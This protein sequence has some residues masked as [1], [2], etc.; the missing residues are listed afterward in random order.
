[1]RKKSFGT[2]IHIIYQ[3]TRGIYTPITIRQ[4]QSQ[5]SHAAVYRGHQNKKKEV[6]ILGIQ[7]LGPYVD[8]APCV[9]LCYQ[10]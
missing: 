8:I 2:F 5:L 9:Y 10:N 6:I 1:M 7:K 3:R 4:F